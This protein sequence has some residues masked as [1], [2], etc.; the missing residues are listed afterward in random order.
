MYAAL[1][2]EALRR[3]FLSRSILTPRHCY[4]HGRSL[5]LHSFAAPGATSLKTIPRVPRQSGAQRREASS[6][7][8]CRR[9]SEVRACCLDDGATCER[10]A[11]FAGT[12]SRTERRHAAY[13]LVDRTA[14]SPPRPAAGRAGGGAA[15]RNAGCV[16]AAPPAL[17]AALG[18]RR[19][20]GARG[21]R[22][23]TAPAPVQLAVL[24]KRGALAS[25]G[26]HAGTEKENSVPTHYCS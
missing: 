8:W 1:P 24:N 16:R 12:L 5:F 10:I 22:A 7:I 21:G 25:G 20:C 23:P 4:S 13:L 19:D 6:R 11:A 14:A 3:S 26:P 17:L 9:A 18:G 15:G 2:N